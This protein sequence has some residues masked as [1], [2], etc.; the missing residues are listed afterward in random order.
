MAC[1][2]VSFRPYGDER[3]H[4]IVIVGLRHPNWVLK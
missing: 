4:Q 2:I 1:P 3:R